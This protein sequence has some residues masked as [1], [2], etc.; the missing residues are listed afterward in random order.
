MPAVLGDPTQ[1]FAHDISSRKS[2]M[3]FLGNLRTFPAQQFSAVSIQA[4]FQMANK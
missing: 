1:D 3:R 4:L 2:Q